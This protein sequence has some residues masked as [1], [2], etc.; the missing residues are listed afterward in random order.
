MAAAGLAAAPMLADLGTAHAATALPFTLNDLPGPTPGRDDL[1]TVARQGGAVLRSA[2][3]FGA[4][5]LDPVGPINSYVVLYG[6]GETLMRLS[7]GGA[8]EP[9]LAERVDQLDALRWRVRLR[10]GVTLLHSE[11]DLLQHR[12]RQPPPWL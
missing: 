12:R 11:H 7:P 4:P 10:S 6:M 3:W 1:T 5:T 8:V 2:E 9:W